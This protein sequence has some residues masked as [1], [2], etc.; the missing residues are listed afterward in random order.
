MRAE[1]PGLD[2]N[3]NVACLECCDML[4]RRLA[5]A[6]SRIR[7]RAHKA[8]GTWHRDL[9]TSERSAPTPPFESP[10]RAQRPRLRSRRPGVVPPD[11]NGAEATGPAARALRKR[12]KRQRHMRSRQPQA[13][14]T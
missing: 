10:D 6:A 7:R 9:K 2:S 11:L 3:L 5:S 8:P 1:G 13:K 14:P 4:G 12:R